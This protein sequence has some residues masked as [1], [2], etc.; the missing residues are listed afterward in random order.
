MPKWLMKFAV[1]AHLGLHRD[2]PELVFQHPRR[3]YSVYLQNADVRPGIALP[4]LH[5]YV[6]YEAEN[7]DVAPEIGG[8]H[9]GDFIDTLTFCTGARFRKHQRLA[10]FDWTPGVAERHGRI[11]KSQPN[12]NVPELILDQ[13]LIPALEVCLVAETT[14]ALR[15]ALRWFSNGVSASYQD[16]QFQMFWFAIETV[17]VFSGGAEKVPDR[18]ARCRTP[19][20]CPSCAEVS[21]HRP[22]PKQK[23]DALFKKHVTSDAEK[24]FL[25]ADA[26]RNA[27][28]H[29][30]AIKGVEEAHGLTL[31]QLVDIV[32]KIAWVALLTAIQ[33]TAE[34][35][36][37]GRKIRLV[38]PTT[39]LHYR[40]EPTAF[41]AFQSPAG[42]EPTFADIPQFDMEMEVARTEPGT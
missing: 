31:A 16:E 23:I 22:Y 6:V 24:F 33:Q 42:R 27:L 21:T 14:E 5:A 12:P 26:M 25:A 15:R 19:L 29:G 34:P 36:S 4:L 40:V 28:L 11:Y 30:D 7:I 9:L 8:R 10:L 35:E 1:K 18:C 39:F 41:V 13:S 37:E 32:G 17:A 3:T 2:V 20:Y 38:Q